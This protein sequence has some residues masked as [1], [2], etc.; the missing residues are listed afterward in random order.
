MKLTA[1][2][3]ADAGVSNCSSTVSLNHTCNRMF[4]CKS[5]GST[6]ENCCEHCIRLYRNRA[7]VFNVTSRALCSNTTLVSSK[8]K[9]EEPRQPFSSPRTRAGVRWRS[10][11][12]TRTWALLSLDLGSAIFYVH[13]FLSLRSNT[14]PIRSCVSLCDDIQAFDFRNHDDEFG[15]RFFDLFRYLSACCSNGWS[16]LILGSGIPIR[17]AGHFPTAREELRI[18]GERDSS[19]HVQQQVKIS[20]A[21]SQ[22]R[23]SICR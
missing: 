18:I 22:P 6:M 9:S 15:H 4:L 13:G 2:Y 21:T 12:T 3:D 23:V 19:Y 10:R 16:Y 7:D 8:V 17:R 20:L 11:H 14:Q 5:K 1:A